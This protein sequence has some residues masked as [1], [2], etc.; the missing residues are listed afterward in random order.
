[1]FNFSTKNWEQNNNLKKDQEIVGKWEAFCC[2][3]AQ[4]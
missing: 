1:M 4:R 2:N 3:F